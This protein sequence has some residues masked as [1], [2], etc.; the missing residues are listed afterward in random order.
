MAIKQITPY[1]SFNGTA[2]K[3]I[4]LYKRALGA[5]VDTLMRWSEMPGEVPDEQKNRVMHASLSI[6]DQ[7]LMIADG[8]IDQPPVVG[9][10]VDICLRFDDKSEMAGRFDALAAGGKVD[11][12]LADQFWGDHFGL[13]TDAFGVHWMFV[14]GKNG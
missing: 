11:M 7:H 5:K 13:L 3:A 4:E 2:D 10:N 12:P 9:S 14:Q 8:K 1:L 6:G